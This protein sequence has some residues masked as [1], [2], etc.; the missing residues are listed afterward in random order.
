MTDDAARNLST[1][2]KLRDGN[3]MP[4]VSFGCYQVKDAG[5]SVAKALQTGYRGC[6]SARVY[7][8]ENAVG[9]AVRNAM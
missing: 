8:N 1:S 3:L 6:D 2:I 7:K 9:E 5:K 4:R